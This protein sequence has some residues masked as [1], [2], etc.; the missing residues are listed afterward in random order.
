MNLKYTVYQAFD[1]IWPGTE[2]S[3]TVLV[4]QAQTT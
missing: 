3:L 4:V 1:T 2:R